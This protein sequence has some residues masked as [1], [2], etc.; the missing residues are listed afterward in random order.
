MEQL[1]KQIVSQQI[2]Q[3]VIDPFVASHPRFSELQPDI[4]MLLKSGIVPDSLN[5]AER[6]ATAYDMAERI[7]P[8]PHRAASAF[9][10]PAPAADPSPDAGRKSVRGAPSD[11]LTPRAEDNL[12][13]DDFLRKEM[14]KIG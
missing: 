12:S 2:Q 3:A 1:E 6:L 8:S 11:G 9:E 14:R 4:E 13:L 5:P 10:E 7:K